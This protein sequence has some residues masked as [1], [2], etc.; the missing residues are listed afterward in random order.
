[1][2]FIRVHWKH[3]DSSYPT[4]LYSEVD[5]AGWELRK[6]EVF[7][8]GALGYASELKAVGG[9]ALSE[10]PLPSLLEIAADP[11]FEPAVISSEEFERA[12]ECAIQGE[13]WLG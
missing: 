11:Q 3:Q 12:W 4:C 1:M 8:S 9:T 2:K 7:S 6:V 13:Q 5:D 10:E